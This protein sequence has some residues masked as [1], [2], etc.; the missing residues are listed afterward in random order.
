MRQL[1]SITPRHKALLH[2]PVG[3]SDLAPGKNAVAA[4][5]SQWQRPELAKEHSGGGQWSGRQEQTF[6]V[7]S[8][9]L[10]DSMRG[11]PSGRP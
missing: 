6:L 2:S 3:I 1:R 8:M 7:Y 10:V 5:G 11:A 4:E 9:R